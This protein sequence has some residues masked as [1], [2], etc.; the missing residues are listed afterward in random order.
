MCTRLLR[1]SLLATLIATP[2][3]AVDELIH[4]LAEDFASMPVRER[5]LVSAFMNAYP[6]ISTPR[7]GDSSKDTFTMTDKYIVLNGE[8]VKQFAGSCVT[9]ITNNNKIIRTEYPYFFVHTTQTIKMAPVGCGLDMEGEFSV[10]GMTIENG[11]SSQITK[12]MVPAATDLGELLTMWDS[13]TISGKNVKYV[14]KSEDGL[15]S[16]SSTI[17]LG[18]TNVLCIGSNSTNSIKGSEDQ[19]MGEEGIQ[20]V[21]Y[22]F[23][24]VSASACQAAKLIYGKAGAD[25]TS[26]V[27]DETTHYC[28]EDEESETG[29]SCSDDASTLGEGEEFPSELID[30][31]P[32]FEA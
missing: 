6:V 17:N 7:V 13:W 31:I 30:G 24:Y 20:T 25:V 29:K 1:M 18:A 19:D 22:E 27:I 16:E 2:A 32:S 4:P 23:K 11:F 5:T 21:I 3:F 12:S 14:F 10:P 15:S 26:T 28:I 8:G 9:T